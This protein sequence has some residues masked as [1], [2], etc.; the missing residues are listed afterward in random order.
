MPCDDNDTACGMVP[1]MF[2][3]FCQEKPSVRPPQATRPG[4]PWALSSMP[5]QFHNDLFY[6]LDG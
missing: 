4:E 1:A 6:R 5:F 3:R 2:I